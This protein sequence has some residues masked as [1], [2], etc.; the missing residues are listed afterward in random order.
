[1]EGWGS[2]APKVLLSQLQM[3]STAHKNARCVGT[4][5][6]HF[7]Q[8]LR[9]T[10]SVHHTLPFHLQCLRSLPFACPLSVTTFYGQNLRTHGLRRLMLQT[11]PSL[12]PTCWIPAQFQKAARG[13]SYSRE[14]IAVYLSSGTFFH[15][16]E[17]L[18]IGQLIEPSKPRWTPSPNPGS[19]MHDCM[20]KLLKNETF[21]GSRTVRSDLRQQQILP[22]IYEERKPMHEEHAPKP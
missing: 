7:F 2:R 4:F 13:K 15:L 3:C 18:R 19:S 9:K 22:F 10:C 20:E 6:F 21:A 1:M 14:I 12:R 16:A 11:C 17:M 5:I 8:L